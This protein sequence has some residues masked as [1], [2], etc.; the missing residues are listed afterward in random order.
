M[1]VFLP[2]KQVVTVQIRYPAPNAPLAQLGEHN[3]DVVGV[4]SSILVESTKYAW[5]V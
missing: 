2:S 1:V 4:I 3:F 5:L